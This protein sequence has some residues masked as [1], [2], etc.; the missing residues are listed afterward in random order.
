MSFLRA[1]LSAVASGAAA[2]GVRPPPLPS[3]APTKRVQDDRDTILINAAAQHAARGGDPDGLDEFRALSPADQ[4]RAIEREIEGL[5][6]KERTEV[7]RL[8]SRW[9]GMKF[10]PMP[11]PQSDAYYSQA[12]ELLYGGSAGGGKQL[13]VDELIPVP[14]EIDPSGF[15]RMGDIVVGDYVFGSGGYPIAVVAV[16]EIDHEPE[17]YAVEFD[18]GEVIEADARHLWVTWTDDERMRVLR[19]SDEWRAKRRASRPSRAKGDASLKPWLRDVTTRLNQEREYKIVAPM[20]GVRTT[21]EIAETLTFRGG[22]LNHSVDVA[23]PITGIAVDLPIEPYL[24]GLWIGDG[25]SKSGAICMDGEDW[26][27]IAHYVPEPKSVKVDTRPPRHRPFVTKRFEGMQKALRLLGVLGAKRIP[28]VYLRASYHQ[29]VAL[30]QG[31]LDTDGHCSRDKGGIEIGLSN[32]VLA[33]D[34]AELVASLGIRARLK[35]KTTKCQTGAGADSHRLH[36]LAPFV[37]FRMSRKAALQK[38]S[39]FRPSTTRRYI[40]SVRPCEPTPMR[41]IQVAAEDGVYLVGRTFIPTHNSGLIIGLALQEHTRSLIFRPKY[42]E[43]SALTE[44]LLKFNGGRDGFRETPYPAM[45][46]KDGRLI[47]FGAAMRPDDASGFFGKPHD[48]LAFDEAALFHESLINVLSTWV[49]TDKKGQRCRVVLATNPPMSAEGAWLVDRYAPWLRKSHP[50]PARPGEL[51]WF[52]TDSDGKDTEVDGP[53]PVE[54]DGKMVEPMSRT[55]IRASLN[56]NVYLADTNYARQ[57]DKLDAPVRAVMRD[58]DW[59][60]YRKD[61]VWQVI[62]TAWVRLAQQRWSPM[63][64]RGQKMTCIGVDVA[65][66]GDD[67]TVLAPRYGEWFA[68]LVIEPGKTTPDGY[69]I[70]SLVTRHI[71]DRAVVAVDTGG[72]WG[73]HAVAHMKELGFT[74]APFLGAGAAKSTP[75]GGY[76]EYANVRAEAYR[77]FRDALDPE[78]EHAIALPPDP[79]LEVELCMPQWD[80]VAL[81]KRG[82]WRVED[83]LDLRNRLG[84]SPDRADAV[85]MSWFMGPTAWQESQAHKPRQTLA[86]VGYA[87]IKRKFG[88]TGGKRQ[89]SYRAQGR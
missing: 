37:A 14:V 39:G 43:L 9:L 21:A 3:Q 11:G 83:K 84:R 78:G 63:P 32:R 7:T 5:P 2:G 42:N 61:D 45:R 81:G 71:R 50:N 67:S 48:L 75:K 59:E 89:T 4:L 82:K 20:G 47:E 18:S 36:F 70:S 72:G 10:I 17:A 22:R 86:N 69:A 26:A 56:D 34:V 76:G 24:F 66:G 27:D 30:L 15:K 79:Q 31:I 64:P 54:V 12:D 28:P 25:I 74:V 33:E 8:L 87:D 57:L 80:Q 53:D 16:S 41:C 1:L 49:R 13:R 35:T 29:R 68:E 23:Q 51:R 46:T 38:L 60:A 19:S 88:T 40:T 58:G 65:Q 85:V 73:G 52:I 62:P 55:F 77:A 6:P 44:D